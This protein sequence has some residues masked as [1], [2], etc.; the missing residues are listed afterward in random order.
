M[1]NAAPV[2]HAPVDPTLLSRARNPMG[3]GTA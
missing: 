2:N 1:R 3:L